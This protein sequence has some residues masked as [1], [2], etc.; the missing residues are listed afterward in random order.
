MHSAHWR[1]ARAACGGSC[2]AEAGCHRNASQISRSRRAPSF[3]RYLFLYSSFF[4]YLYVY[5]VLYLYIYLFCGES[6]SAEAGSHLNGSQIS[7]WRKAHWFTRYSYLYREISLY[8]YIYIVHIY[9]A[10]V[11]I[12]VY[13]LRRKLQR[14]G[15]VPPQRQPDLS[16]AQGTLVHEVFIYIYIGL[17]FYIYLY[18]Y[19]YIYISI[20]C[21][22]HIS[23]SYISISISATAAG[24]LARE[25]H[26][27]ACGIYIYIGLPLY[28]YLYIY[29]DIYISISCCIHISISYIS[30]SISATAA[31]PL[32]GARHPR[33]RGFSCIYI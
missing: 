23:I 27:R 32:A 19:L 25:G 6:C 21:C 33:P 13:L 2:S 29:L 11:S 31:R 30:I 15:W 10:V 28:I 14:G 18:I 9:R 16:L 3:M 17:P 5:I 20:S 24:P 7:R 1:A 12:Y 22:I 26:P 4:L 8:I